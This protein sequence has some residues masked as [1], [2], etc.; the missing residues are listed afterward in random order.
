MYL[1]GITSEHDEDVATSRRGC[2]EAQGMSATIKERLSAVNQRAVAFAASP[3][4]KRFARVA[5]YA[6]T[7][8]IVVFLLVRLTQIGWGS[9][10]TSLPTTPW[11]YLF[12]LMLYFSLPIA[13][14]VVYGILWKDTRASDRF[15]ALIKKRV[16]NRDVLGYSGE[17]YLATWGRRSTGRSDGDVLRNVRDVNI[18]SSAASTTVALILL[19][20]FLLLGQ[21]NVQAWVDQPLH[22]VIGAAIGVLVLAAVLWPVRRYLFALAWKL[23]L[24]IFVIYAGRLLMGQVL[25]IAQWAV[26]LPEIPFTTWFTFAAVSLIISRVPFLP[27]HDLIFAGAGIE[28][29]RVLGLPAAEIAAMLLLAGVLDKLMNLT[30]FALVSWRQGRNSLSANG[31]NEP[32]DHAIGEVA[33]SEGDRLNP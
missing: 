23:A 1:D 18:L 15:L 9:I 33:L 5:R 22:Y 25:Q 3:N 24:V 27:S 30:M 7:A 28:L 2:V 31:T 17:V 32:V 21:I 26:V 12:F 29:A 8:A 16:F 11:F 13:E 19:A 20:V 10:L 14:T 4:G 6:F